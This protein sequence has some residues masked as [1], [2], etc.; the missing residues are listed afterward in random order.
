MNV[1]VRRIRMTTLT[2][3]ATM[4]V[5]AAP[6]SA[7]PVATGYAEGLS[8]T[9]TDIA[10]GPDGNV[11]FTEAGDPGRIGRITRSGVITEFT[12][13]LTPNA[14]PTGIAAGPDGAMWFTERAKARI[15]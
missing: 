8:A 10:L 15:G 11:W 6:A 7:A 13:G 3:V 12:A 1:G 5:A 9:A 4:L 2:I 14:Q